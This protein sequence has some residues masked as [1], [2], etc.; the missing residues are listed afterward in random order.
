MKKMAIGLIALVAPLVTGPCIA[1]PL[2]F[3]YTG[4]VRNITLIDGATDS[5]GLSV[6]SE[7]SGSFFFDHNSVD[8]D[9]S[10][11]RAFYRDPILRMRFDGVQSTPR[12]YD[13]SYFEIDADPVRNVVS[14][15]LSTEYRN[16]FEIFTF[17]L[18]SPPGFPAL[19]SDQPDWQSLGLADFDLLDSRFD[20]LRAT[21][22]GPPREYQGGPV[23]RSLISAGFTS[24]RI[25]PAAVPEPG[26]LG[27]L[28]LGLAGLGISRKKRARG[29]G[30]PIVVA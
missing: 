22:T 11:M 18:E 21:F 4:I 23:P 28:G 3:Q 25:R 29:V 15:Y 13:Y 30:V 19:T 9:G 10:P 5:L 26:T 17:V 12:I 20:F 8:T 14:S 27:L 1:V 24:L 2:I 6:G 16:I 7:I